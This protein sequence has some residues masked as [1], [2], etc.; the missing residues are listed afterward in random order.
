MSWLDDPPSLHSNSL[1][2][3]HKTSFDFR[4]LVDDFHDCQS[5][6]LPCIAHRESRLRPYVHHINLKI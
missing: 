5:T 3:V 6:L 1:F 4:Q 2:E